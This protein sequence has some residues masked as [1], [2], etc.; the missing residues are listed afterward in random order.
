MLKA[1]DCENIH[2]DMPAFG[3]GG[4]AGLTLATAR[5]DGLRDPFPRS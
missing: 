3:L 1:E 5:M 2:R 4:A